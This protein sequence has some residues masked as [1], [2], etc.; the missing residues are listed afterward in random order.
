MGKPFTIDSRG[1][2]TL[3]KSVRE[4]VGLRANRGVVIEVKGGEVVLK[5]AIGY[6][7]F[8]AA[9]EG[10][11]KGSKVKPDE[12]REIWGIDHAHY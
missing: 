2:I 9:L 7:E 12:L 1:R 8:I 10:C 5:P 4:Q 6:E 11:V 3:P